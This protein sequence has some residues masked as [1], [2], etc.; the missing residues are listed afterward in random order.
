MTNW[1]SKTI[2][3]LRRVMRLSQSEFARRIGVNVRTLQG[4]ELGR[5]VSPLGC[6]ILDIFD[7]ETEVTSIEEEVQDHDNEPI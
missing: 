3:A 5:P 2:K 7:R 4:W 1:N 6:T